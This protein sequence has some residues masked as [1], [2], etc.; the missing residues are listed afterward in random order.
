MNTVLFTRH[1]RSM[2]DNLYPGGKPGHAVQSIR[3]E[4]RRWYCQVALEI[5]RLCS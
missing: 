4:D 1:I 3:D 2:P 5:A